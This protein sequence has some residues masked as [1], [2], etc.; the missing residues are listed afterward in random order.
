MLRWVI[1]GA[2][3]GGVLFA[4]FFVFILPRSRSTPVPIWAS[5]FYYY[6]VHPVSDRALFRADGSVDSDVLSA[7]FAILDKPGLCPATRPITAADFSDHVVPAAQSM[8]HSGAVVIRL[9]EYVP[10]DIGDFTN[11]WWQLVYRTSEGEQDVLTLWMT[12]PYRISYF[13][14]TRYDTLLG[15]EEERFISFDGHPSWQQIE[16]NTEGNFFFEGNYGASI[17]R[18]N[19]LRDMD[20]VLSIFDVSHFLIAPRSIPGEWQSAT[21][22]TGTNA[23]REYFG[24]GAAGLIWAWSTHFHIGNGK[25]GMNDGIVSGGWPHSPAIATCCDLLWLPSDFEVRS[26]GHSN[27]P[28]QFQT[29]IAYPENPTSHLRWNYTIREE[30]TREDLTNGRSGLWQLNGFDRAFYVPADMGFLSRLVWLRSADSFAIG[31]ANTVCHTGNRYG[32]GVNHPIG[33][34]PAIHISISDLRMLK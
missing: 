28:A 18:Y 33:L 17:A 14:G 8:S 5:H 13:G 12:E 16:Q 31:N 1:G 7:L 34:R 19:L 15:Y 2:L 24:Q 6:N 23:Y 10:G 30:D 11:S 27:E 21:A 32:I 4:L 29:F 20:A 22:Q 26:M 9:F 25:D 3:G